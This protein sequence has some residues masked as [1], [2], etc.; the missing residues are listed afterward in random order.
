MNLSSAKDRIQEI[1]K[2]K[3]RNIE[4]ELLCQLLSQFQVKN[5]LSLP[6]RV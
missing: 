2:K 5:S 6:E 3:L 1:H 4:H